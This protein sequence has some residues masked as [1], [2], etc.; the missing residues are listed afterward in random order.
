MTW[1]MWLILVVLM[2]TLLALGVA[3]LVVHALPTEITALLH[4]ARRRYPSAKLH[5]IFQPHLFSRTQFFAEE[6]AQALALADDVLVTGVFPARERQSDFPGVGPDTIVQAARRVETD[7]RQGWISAVGN[8]QLAA[9]MMTMRAHHGDVVFI[10]GAGDI[11]SMG[12][13][14]IHALEAHRDGCED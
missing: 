14:L 3:Y 11:S 5:V 13:V 2:L 7:R 4:A 8:M 1:W 10:V 9:K 12:P 6:F